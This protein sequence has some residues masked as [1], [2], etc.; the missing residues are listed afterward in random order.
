MSA[1]DIA[2]VQTL[3][4]IQDRRSGAPVVREGLRTRSLSFGT[5]DVQTTMRRSDPFSLE[6][7]YA[8]AMMSFQLFQPLPR[9]ILIV[10]LG[11]GSLSKYCHRQFPDA[12][13]TSVE[14]D[15]RVIALREQF[16][17]PADSDRFRIVHAD[18]ADYL[19]GMA[20]GD[21]TV[22]V[23]LLDGFNALGLP[24]RLSSQSFYD[25]CYAALRADGVLVA[26]LLEHDPRVA[27]HI[28]RIRLA[29]GGKLLCTAARREGNVIAVGLRHERAPRWTELHARAQALEAS[30]GLNLS[31][32]VKRMESRYYAELKEFRDVPCAGG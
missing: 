2:L 10:G 24:D 23:I 22:D 6:L 8:R 15:E 5:L 4:E 29:C 27:V 28:E 14:I 1:D 3:A 18:A 19:A 31:L 12:R 11:G 25:N 7:S 21:A 26:N 16:H 17:I 30:T 9:H 32:H 20:N 13:I